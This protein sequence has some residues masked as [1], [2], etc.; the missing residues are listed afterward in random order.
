MEG[1]RSANYRAAAAEC[2]RAAE[3]CTRAGSITF[4]RDLAARWTQ[5]AEEQERFEQE[6]K[7]AA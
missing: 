7:R 1:L 3:R 4:F 6:A 5:L 2:L